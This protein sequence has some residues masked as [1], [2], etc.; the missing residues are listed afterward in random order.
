M[1]IKHFNSLA[2]FSVL[3]CKQDL[4]TRTT[5]IT[6]T[7]WDLNRSPFGQYYLHKYVSKAEVLRLKHFMLKLCM[8]LLQLERCGW[9]SKCRKADLGERNRMIW[10]RSRMLERGITIVPLALLREAAFSEKRDANP[11]CHLLFRQTDREECEPL[12]WT[13]VCRII[14]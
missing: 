10:S 9:K 4:R 13:E 1:R 3:K 11:S 7:W 2:V 8:S 12:D 6:C 14:S 5:V